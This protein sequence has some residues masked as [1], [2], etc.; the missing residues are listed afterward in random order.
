MGDLLFSLVNVARWLGIDA[1]G[2]LRHA[3]DRFF[4]RYAT[5]EEL[6]RKRD[7]SLVD[8]PLDKKEALWQE[9]KR[10]VG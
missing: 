2:A 1:E 6:S 9:S 10:I 8:L 3:N 5:V 4:R 7:L